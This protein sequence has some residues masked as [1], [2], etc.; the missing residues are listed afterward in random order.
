MEVK[1]CFNIVFLYGFTVI[2]R[3]NN[4]RIM[5]FYANPGFSKPMVHQ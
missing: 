4:E 3:D 1:W 5:A 2:N